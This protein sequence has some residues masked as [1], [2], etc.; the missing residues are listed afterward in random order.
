MLATAK[1]QYRKSR[2]GVEHRFQ[3]DPNT[4]AQLL[5]AQAVIREHLDMGESLATILRRAIGAYSE[6]LSG[7][8]RGLRSAPTRAQRARDEL[9]GERWRIEKAAMGSP[10][11]GGIV[12]LESLPDGAGSLT[13]QELEAR[14]IDRRPVIEQLTGV[15]NTTGKRS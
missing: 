4:Y 9:G 6:K 13:Y 12:D 5:H 1:H 15:A 10:A 14:Y 2:G 7:I 3:L 11:P 8:Q